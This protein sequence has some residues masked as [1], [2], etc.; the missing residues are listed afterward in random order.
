MRLF[1][2]NIN[3]YYKL[4]AYKMKSVD[5]NCENEFIFF[6]TVVRRIFSCL[7]SHSKDIPARKM[8]F[9]DNKII[10]KIK[11]KEMILTFLLNAGILYTDR[12][13]WLYK[14]NT[15]KLGEYSI[16]WNNVNTGE[17]ES[18]TKLYNS[19]VAVTK[20]EV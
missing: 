10:G 6:A 3:S 16:R 11:S 18:L 9:I 19:F 2:N 8:D 1:A 5:E 13:D 17:L 12:Q 7:R 20:I 15:N 4:L 14:L